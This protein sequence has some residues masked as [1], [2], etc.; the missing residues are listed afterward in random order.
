MPFYL[1]FVPSVQIYQNLVVGRKIN[2]GMG[3]VF[4]TIGRSYFM[5]ASFLKNDVEIKT[6]QMKKNSHLKLAAET[7][8][9]IQTGR[10]YAYCIYSIRVCTFLNGIYTLQFLT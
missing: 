5:M 10:V 6:A 7:L 4:Q 1:V 2:L 8:V 9:G 3:F